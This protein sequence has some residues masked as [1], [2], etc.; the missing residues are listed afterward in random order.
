M[1]W[2]PDRRYVLDDRITTSTGVSANIPVMRAL[3]EAIGGHVAASRVASE[4]GADNW[5][6]RHRSAAFTLSAE[7]KKT[8]ICNSLAL[9]RHET[10][11]IPLADGIDEVAL[12]SAATLA[13]AF[14]RRL[15][16]TPQLYRA[17]FGH[18]P[19]PFVASQPDTGGEGRRPQA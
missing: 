9:W 3:V 18:Q 4:L 5:D 13:R 6:A 1:H 10:I 14:R 17:R 15:G 11:G 8:F 19:D 7:H 16:V 12:G 2:V